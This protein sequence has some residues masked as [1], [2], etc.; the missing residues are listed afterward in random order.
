MLVATTST[1]CATQ[2]SAQLKIQNNFNAVMHVKMSKELSSKAKF[3]KNAA[4]D[5]Q[6]QIKHKKI[7]GLI[8][9]G[10]TATDDFYVEVDAQCK[11]NAS[12]DAVVMGTYKFWMQT[13]S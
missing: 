3:E 9:Y 8:D 13:S 4:Y 1:M 5:I 2:V 10:A 7:T 12:V 11:F 6:P